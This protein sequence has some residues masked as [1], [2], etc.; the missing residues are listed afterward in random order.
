MKHIWNYIRIKL[1][2][3]H[4]VIDGND[5]TVTV[6]K[7]LYWALLL[8]GLEADNRI[9]VFRVRDTFGFAVS[10]SQLKGVETNFYELQ[11]N[12]KTKTIG[13]CPTCPSVA[14]ILND[15]SL[16]HDSVVRR[17][18]ATHISKDMVYFVIRRR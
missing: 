3:K 14:L 17:K 1:M 2:P 16:P 11:Y 15:F 12:S 4:V 9:Y 7:W 13:F 5:G 18:V 8:M 6:S 10:P